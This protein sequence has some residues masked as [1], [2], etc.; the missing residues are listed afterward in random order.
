MDYL[1]FKIDGEFVCRLARTWFWDE[2]RPYEKC[3]ELLLDCLNTEEITLEEKKEIVIEILEGRSKLVGLNTFQLIDDGENVRKL[4]E[5]IKENDKKNLIHEILVDME[6]NPISYVDKYAARKELDD[7]ENYLKVTKDKKSID[8][9]VRWLYSNYNS[10]KNS[11]SLNKEQLDMEFGLRRGAYL[12]NAHLVY[13][14]FGKPLSDVNE[15]EKYNKLFQYLEHSKLSDEIFFRQNLYL[16]YL[17]KQQSGSPKNAS[18]KFEREVCYIPEHDEFVSPYG[19]IDPD[20]NYYSCGFGGH[21]AKA[22]AIIKKYPE[23]FGMDV[24]AANSLLVTADESEIL[25]EKGWFI[26]HNK[27]MMGD[28]YF[29]VNPDVEITDQQIKKAFDYMAH[30]GRMDMRCITNVIENAV[31]RKGK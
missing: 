13:D 24:K 9:V 8:S 5:K 20:G 15:C 4:S 12:M 30:F 31:R 26:V 23:K 14:L 17:R 22:Y 7:Y 21:A 10:W 16:A 6:R 1:Q 2:N 29:K 11:Y 25:Y 28:P 27:S 3:E 19:L 18:I